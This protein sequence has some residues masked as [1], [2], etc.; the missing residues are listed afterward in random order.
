MLPVKTSA[1]STS[2][3]LSPLSTIPLLKID[4]VLFLST[5]KALDV[6]LKPKVFSSPTTSSSPICFFSA[7]VPSVFVVFL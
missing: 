3:T 2:V 1:I 4:K 6:V 5:S 7:G